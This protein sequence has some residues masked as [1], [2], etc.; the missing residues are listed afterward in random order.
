MD[1][2]R[3]F[4]TGMSNGAILS[5]RLAC[6]LSSRIAAIAPVAGTIGVATCTPGRAV[7]VM[8]IHGTDDG[9]VP[10]TGGTGCGPAGVAFNSVP[11]TIEGWRTRNGCSATTTTYLQ[12]GDGTC[13]A[14]EGCTGATVLCSIEGGGH[15]WPGGVPKTGVVDCPA[16]GIQSTTFFASE[17]AWQ[18]FRSNPMR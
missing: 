4:A 16:D 17:A 5:H 3:V 7:P 2:R 18:F 13:T 9:H 14:Y 1:E 12:Q 10:W 8:E 15:S 11:D 6:E